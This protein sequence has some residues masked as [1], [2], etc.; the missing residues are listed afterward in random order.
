ML[1][2]AKWTCLILVGLSKK[3]RNSPCR[4]G[5]QF[6][7][8]REKLRLLVKNLLM[9]PG[10]NDRETHLFSED[11]RAIKNSPINTNQNA[12]VAMS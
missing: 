11:E 1:H 3:G 6:R 9:S 4:N 8:W 2:A 5:E 10:R 12:V 7:P